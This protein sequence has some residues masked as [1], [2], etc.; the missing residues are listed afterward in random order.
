MTSVT[1]QAPSPIS[2]FPSAD[3]L[4]STDLLFITQPS[5]TKKSKKLTLA[6]FFNSDVFKNAASSSNTSWIYPDEYEI[7]EGDYLVEIEIDT[8]IDVN[9]VQRIKLPPN[10]IQRVYFTPSKSDFSGVIEVAIDWASYPN[11]ESATIGDVLVPYKGGARLY[12]SNGYYKSG[13]C[14]SHDA[15]ILQM[16]NIESALNIGVNST[17][18]NGYFS[19]YRYNGTDGYYHF[20][21]GDDGMYFKMERSQGFSYSG[22]IYCADGEPNI[23]SGIVAS[24][25]GVKFDAAVGGTLR[26]NDG[27]VCT[28]SAS[29]G[30]TLTAG[31]AILTNLS[32]DGNAT[33]KNAIDVQY[34]TS[35][36]VTL[37]LSGN[38][39]AVGSVS[40]GTHSSFNQNAITLNSQ[41][42]IVGG[43]MQTYGGFSLGGPSLYGNSEEHS[44][45]SPVDIKAKFDADGS[46]PIGSLFIFSNL[47]SGS[48]V[49]I[50]GVQGAAT[51]NKIAEVFRGTSALIVKVG[52]NI[53]QR[54]GFDDF[55]A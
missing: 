24:F 48:D 55:T 30:E 19:F 6:D 39:T 13:Q 35:K 41:N 23:G 34:G 16:A 17:S 10:S 25:Q 2:M 40:F 47:L 36:M 31:G 50:S 51:G 7:D 38:L 9:V 18:A 32:V 45:S 14:L 15:S 53:Y 54:V 27:L 37:N 42:V 49:Y 26:L 5:K 11:G 44:S 28:G 43:K 4:D 29:V 1:P 3:T 46:A 22:S 21:M 33:F 12:Y 8:A 52:T 20:T